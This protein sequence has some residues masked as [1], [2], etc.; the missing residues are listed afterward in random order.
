V[1]L[2]NTVFSK[3]LVYIVNGGEALRMIFIGRRDH[4]GGGSMLASRD[5]GRVTL[6][7]QNAMH[8]TSKAHHI[9][10]VDWQFRSKSDFDFTRG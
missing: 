5:T 4:K 10:K 8:H 9:A 6:A 3:V 7:R 2:S 1:W